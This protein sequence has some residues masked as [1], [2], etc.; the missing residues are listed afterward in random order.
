VTDSDQPWIIRG[1]VDADA[2]AVQLQSE[3]GLVSRRGVMRPQG[4]ADDIGAF[5]VC[6]V[7]LLPLLNG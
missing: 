6:F 2:G 7:T 5:E 4:A 1:S 3:K